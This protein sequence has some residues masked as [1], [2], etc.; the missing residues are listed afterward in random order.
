M[1]NKRS[2]KNDSSLIIH[3]L[4]KHWRYFLCATLA[5]LFSSAF[6]LAIGKIIGYSIASIYQH[7]KLINIF[8]TCLIAVLLLSLGVL[9]RIILIAYGGEKVIEDLRKDLYKKIIYSPIDNINRRFNN[10]NSVLTTDITL[11]QNFFASGI[12]IFLRNCFTLFGSIILLIY[13]DPELSLYASI[14]IPVILLAI[15][16]IGKKVKFYAKKSRESISLIAA[17]INDNFNNI[18]VIKSFIAEKLFIN[19]FNKKAEYASAAFIKYSI[20]RAVLISIIIA[21]VFIAVTMLILIGINNILTGKTNAV[22]LSEFIFYALLAAS[23][24]NAVTEVYNDYQQIIIVD[25]RISEL[26]NCETEKSETDIES[27]L[28]VRRIKEFKELSFENVNFSYLPYEPYDSQKNNNYNEND[29]SNEDNENNESNEDNSNQLAKKV[30]IKILPTQYILKNINFTISVGESIAIVGASGAGKSTI[31]NLLLRFYKVNS[32]RIL[33]N[34]ININELSLNE[35]R[36]LFAL[37]FQDPCLFASTIAENIKIANPYATQEELDNACKI[38]AVNEF[39][40]SLPEGLN[41]SINKAREFSRGQ[42]Q[43][44][45]ISRAVLKNSPIILFDEATSS[46]DGKNE[47]LIQNSLLELKRRN[48]SITIIIIAHRL[49][50]IKN[51]NKIIVLKEGS[52]EAIGDHKYLLENSLFYKSLID[53]EPQKS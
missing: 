25:K 53:L 43:R 4:K 14:I 52:I 23:S 44:I 27:A 11:L 36:E 37:V 50:T 16:I 31:F 34:G 15:I 47:Q 13:T 1:S 24:T 39:V 5:V 32:G 51:S 8:F 12:S 38:A 19:N 41:T 17:N 46:L 35:L 3:Y 22:A 33:I 10:I 42:Q 29:E 2:N 20:L 9:F 6:A 48:S 18:K 49:S 26:Y 28:E 40:D 7:A 30:F 21:L 45:A